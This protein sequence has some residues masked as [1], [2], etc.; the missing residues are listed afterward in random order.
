[1]LVAT[2]AITGIPFFAGFFSK[3]ANPLRRI[4]EPTGGT[5]LYAFGLLT[6]CLPPST[7]SG[8]SS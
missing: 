3:D 5:V 6:A 2:F 8:L 1:M 4:S 7:C